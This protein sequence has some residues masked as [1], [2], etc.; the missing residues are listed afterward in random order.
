MVGKSYFAIIWKVKFQYLLSTLPELNSFGF[1]CPKDTALPL[2]LINQTSN[3]F[4]T[5]KK[6]KQWFLSK[7]SQVYEDSIK[8][9]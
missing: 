7:S 3:Q 9:S 6:G 4:P 2:V 8:P 5:N 1:S